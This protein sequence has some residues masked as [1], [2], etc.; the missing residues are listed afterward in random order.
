MEEGNGFLRDLSGRTPWGVVSPSQGKGGLQ[1]RK[2]PKKSKNTHHCRRGGY[3]HD[4]E[5]LKMKEGFLKHLPTVSAIEEKTGSS[6]GGKKD[7]SV[8]VRKLSIMMRSSG[9]KKGRLSQD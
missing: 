6:V 9:K 2:E 7:D 1:M 8:S 3:L 4:L 5:L